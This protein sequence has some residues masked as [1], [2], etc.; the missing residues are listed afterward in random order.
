MQAQAV[1]G[2]ASAIR[3]LGNLIQ[4]VGAA[5]PMGKDIAKAIYDLN[6]HVPAGAV[7][8]AGEMN[9]LDGL[10]QHMMQQAPQ[11]AAMKAMSGGGAGPPSG[12]P[13]GAAP[14]GGGAPAMPPG[15]GL[16]G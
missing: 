9:Q 12:L 6:K 8:P 2:M 14:P 1:Q 7:S 3:M 5:S 4:K 15:G 16:P 13:G 11:M 10:R